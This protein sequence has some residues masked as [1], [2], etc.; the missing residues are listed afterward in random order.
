MVS[1]GDTRS[2][3]YSSHGSVRKCA[4][5]GDCKTQH[6][7]MVFVRRIPCPADRTTLGLEKF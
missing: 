6:W 5:R 1:K 3:D 7:A 2:L 4:W